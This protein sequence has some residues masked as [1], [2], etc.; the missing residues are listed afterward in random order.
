M[1]ILCWRN[2]AGNAGRGQIVV[3]LE[4]NDFFC[5]QWGQLKLYLGREWWELIHFQVIYTK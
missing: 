5:R 2:W 3:V 4:E 1:P